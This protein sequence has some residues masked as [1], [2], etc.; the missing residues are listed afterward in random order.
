MVHQLEL[1]RRRFNMRY[2]T[3]TTG[4]MSNIFDG[5]LKLQ[6][7]CSP[8]DWAPGFKREPP[9]LW[10][11]PTSQQRASPLPAAKAI[12]KYPRIKPAIGELMKIN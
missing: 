9:C 1:V 7:P 6:M 5:A 4:A 3:D 2:F 8:Q 12:K 11:F 10:G